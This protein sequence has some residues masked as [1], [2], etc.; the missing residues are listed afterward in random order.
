MLKSLGL[1]D[2]TSAK[3]SQ[4]TRTYQSKSWTFVQLVTI[5]SW[6]KESEKVSAHN[7]FLFHDTFIVAE[8]K[9][10]WITRKQT[11]QQKRPPNY[12]SKFSAFQARKEKSNHSENC[13]MEIKYSCKSEAKNRFVHLKCVGVINVFTESKKTEQK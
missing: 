2:L 4:H 12:L 8:L 7:F 3:T 10:N 13:Q 5:T 11:R 9:T 6:E 1:F